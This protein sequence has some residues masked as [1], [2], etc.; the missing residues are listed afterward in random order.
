MHSNVHRETPRE[1]HERA[2]LPHAIQR[3][4]RELVCVDIILYCYWH[5]RVE[6]VGVLRA[7][8]EPLALRQPRDPLAHRRPD[9]IR[10]AHPEPDR[11][12]ISSRSDRRSRHKNR[13]LHA[14]DPYSSGT[15]NSG[16]CHR[17]TGVGHL[18][19]RPET[20]D[21]ES[22]PER[23]DVAQED[24]IL[25]SIVREEEEPLQSVWSHLIAVLTS[26]LLFRDSHS[27]AQFA[28]NQ[29]GASFRGD[30]D[31]GNCSFTESLTFRVVEGG[32]EVL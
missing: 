29:S 20:N 12:P 28:S 3:H 10:T 17:A 1:P 23:L 31:R 13:G 9:G 4:D 5:H 25:I 14:R 32:G 24:F 30:Y 11:I 16:D 6:D 18:V 2:H 19:L 8:R 22:R 15:R 27:D 21:E 7:L 26:R